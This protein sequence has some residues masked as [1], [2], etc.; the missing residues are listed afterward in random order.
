MII[1]S[2]Q[3]WKMEHQ[4]EGNDINSNLLWK[5]VRQKHLITFWMCRVC[6]E[7]LFRNKNSNFILEPGETVRANFQL[8]KSCALTNMKVS[9]LQSLP[10]KKSF[11]DQSGR[12]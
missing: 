9:D 8:C 2:L 7:V 1:P 11:A 5:L 4:N 3:D 12:S 6:S 10:T